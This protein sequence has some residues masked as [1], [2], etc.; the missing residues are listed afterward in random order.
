M[1]VSDGNRA[2]IERILSGD[3]ESFA[4]IVSEYKGLVFHVVQSM[5]SDRMQQEDLA[6]DIFIRLFESLGRFRLQCSLATWISRIAYN[7]CLNYLRRSKSHPQDNPDYRTGQK[8]LYEGKE[9]KR[10]YMVTVDSPTPHSV[11]CQKELATAVTEA[12][13]RLPSTYR[14]VIALHYLEGFT[15]PELGESLGMPVGTI[16][17]H[18]FRARGMLKK[19]LLKRFTIEDLIE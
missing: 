14:L 4:A 2:L 19:D 8:S 10:D 16:K 3:T 13:E 5:V 18:L 9:I 1:V 6:Q 17:S 12:I 7:M 11:I 15:L